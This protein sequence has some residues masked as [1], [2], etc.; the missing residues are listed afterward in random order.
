MRISGVYALVNETKDK[1]YIGS[2]INVETR[3]KT[4]FSQLRHGKHVCKAMQKDFS[5]GDTFS[6]QILETHE[7]PTQSFLFNREGQWINKY[8][9]DKSIYNKLL[10]DGEYFV[11]RDMLAKLMLDT[12]CQSFFHKSYD[13]LTA[14]AKPAEI[15]MLYMIIKEPEREQEIREEYREM[16]SAQNRLFYYQT[17]TYYHRFP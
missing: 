17:R 12:F 13:H 8:K 2:S 4:H 7:N 5:D 6:S 15:E 14:S 16:I 10:M 1:Y 9:D 11:T 3:I